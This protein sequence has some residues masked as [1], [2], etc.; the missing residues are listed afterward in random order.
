MLIIVVFSIRERSS[1]GRRAKSSKPQPRTR[2]T[3]RI[4]GTRFDVYDCIEKTQGNL[5][6]TGCTA[7][8]SSVRR[9]RKSATRPDEGGLEGVLLEWWRGGE[10]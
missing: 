8:R 6:D 4:E 10:R 1:N 3:S 9:H 5:S 7:T 2:P